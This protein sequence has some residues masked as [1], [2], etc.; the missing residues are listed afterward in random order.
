MSIS[1]LEFRRYSDPDFSLLDQE[2]RKIKTRLIVGI[3]LLNIFLFLSG[4]ALLIPYIMAMRSYEYIK[5]LQERERVDKLIELAKIRV[6]DY[7]ARFA[8]FAL[9][10]MKVKDAAFIL[11]DLQEEAVYIFTNFSKKLQKALDVLAAKL[12]YN[13]AEEML[14]LLEKPTQRYGIVPSIPI[15]SVYYLDD[16][17]IKAKCMIS[18]LLLDFNDD[19]VVACPSCGNL[20]KRELLIEWLEENG[21]CKIC[22]RKISMRECPIVKVRE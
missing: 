8:I 2:W 17:P 9:V 22:E 11:N 18:D 21:S 6:G 1:K 20:A 19:N 10:D 15:T 4:F 14:R 13:S 16:E 12:D 5:M 7:N 3:I